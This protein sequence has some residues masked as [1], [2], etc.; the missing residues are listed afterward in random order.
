MHGLVEQLLG[1]H[2]GLLGWDLSGTSL[3]GQGWV[4]GLLALSS[5]E[6]LLVYH[7]LENKK[8]LEEWGGTFLEV[9]LDQVGPWLLEY[10][11]GVLRLNTFL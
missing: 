9:V 2:D 5:Q 6:R 7:H 1:S 8:I 3:Q 11:A 10:P 4:R